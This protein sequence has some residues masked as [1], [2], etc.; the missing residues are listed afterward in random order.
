MKS[1]A[2]SFLSLFMTVMLLLGVLSACTTT[3]TPPDQ[4]TEE[5]TTPEQP[6]ETE[7]ESEAEAETQPPLDPAVQ[8]Q[9]LI[10]GQAFVNPAPEYRALK[11]DHNFAYL[12]GETWEQKAASLVEYGFGGAACN[13]R[14]DGNYLQP[15]QSLDDFAAFVQAAHKQGVR[16]WL[17]DEYGYPSGSAGNLTVKDHPEYAAIRLV[18]QTMQGGDADPRSIKLPDGFIKVEH[19]YLISEGQT[20]EEFKNLAPNVRFL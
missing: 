15:G 18:Q 5:Q 16:I 1:F 14:W 2:K 9:A 6:T 8:N 12:P 13:M 4:S 3:P 19:A 11:I 10:D 7:S 17:Y 20:P